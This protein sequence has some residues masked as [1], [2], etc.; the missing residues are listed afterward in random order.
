M[1]LKLV[2]KKSVGP[3]ICLAALLLSSCAHDP[4]PTR[5]VYEVNITRGICGQYEIVD[6]R[7]LTFRHVRDLP[8]A[9]CQGTFGFHA[10]DAGKV[11]AWA[12]RMIREAEQ[13]CTL[14]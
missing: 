4:F 13:K 2:K 6:T 3:W 11:F 12:R 10:A 1:K 8:L 9:Q 14:P 7:N 5:H